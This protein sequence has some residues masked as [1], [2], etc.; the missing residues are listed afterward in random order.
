MRNAKMEME[1]SQRKMEKV[2]AKE[3][4]KALSANC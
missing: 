2:K 3:K 4:N 1:V